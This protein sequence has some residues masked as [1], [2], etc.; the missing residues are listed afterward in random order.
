[1]KNPKKSQ[2]KQKKKTLGCFFL[3]EF[4]PTLPLFEEK[5]TLKISDHSTFY[6]HKSPVP[7]ML[8]DFFLVMTGKECSLPFSLDLFYKNIYFKAEQ[9]L[10]NFEGVE[11]IKPDKT[12]TFAIRSLMCV[13]TVLGR[14]KNV[15][16]YSLHW[17]LFAVQGCM[18]QIV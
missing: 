3:T 11:S 9:N 7:Y 18:F 12:V 4:F 15:F 1:M 2:E 6:D 13:F 16:R 8:S 10:L 17:P 5:K 14:E